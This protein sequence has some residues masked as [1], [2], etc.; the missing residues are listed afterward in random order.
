MILDEKI[1]VSLD[2]DIY[3]Y[4]YRNN[5]FQIRNYFKTNSSLLVDELDRIIKLLAENKIKFNI[6]KDNTVKILD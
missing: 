4:N 5:S 3:K 1:L 2:C 6:L